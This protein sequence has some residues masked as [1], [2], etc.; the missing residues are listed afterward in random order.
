MKD[1]PT[2]PI[3]SNVICVLIC[4]AML[5]KFIPL[6]PT[7]VLLLPKILEKLTH[8]CSYFWGWGKL[9]DVKTWLPI[10][11]V[12]T[13]KQSFSLQEQELY[14]GWLL[15]PQSPVWLGLKK[16]LWFRLLN[17]LLSVLFSEMFWFC[18]TLS[19]L[20]VTRRVTALHATFRIWNL[21]KKTLKEKQNTVHYS[22]ILVTGPRLYRA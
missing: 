5:W 16:I 22:F 18:A 3:S 10:P 6:C 1:I 4:H 14:L 13:G 15:V 2:N 9:E 20:F 7:S 11:R 21:M 17:F 19:N 12:T 8:T